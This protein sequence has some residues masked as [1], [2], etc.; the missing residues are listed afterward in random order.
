MNLLNFEA[1]IKFSFH[2]CCFSLIRVL[3]GANLL[4]VRFYNVSEMRLF[5]LTEIKVSEVL[6]SECCCF[7]CTS[8][9]LAKCFMEDL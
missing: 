7:K 6:T 2:R 4:K 5:F 9:L 3:V 8:A 1:T